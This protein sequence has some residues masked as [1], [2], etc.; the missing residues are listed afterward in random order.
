MEQQEQFVGHLRTRKHIILCL[1]YQSVCTPDGLLLSLDCS[2]NCSNMLFSM[3]RN[4][5]YMGMRDMVS[6]TY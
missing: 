2:N 4:L 5:C 1:K 3:I 6:R